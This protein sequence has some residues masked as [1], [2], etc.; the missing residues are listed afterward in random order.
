MKRSVFVMVLAL[1]TLSACMG[2]VSCPTCL[3][4]VGDD[5]VTTDD[6]LAADDDDAV[7]G[8]GFTF[9]PGPLQIEPGQCGA[10]V[11]TAVPSPGFVT[12][13]DGAAV[14]LAVPAAVTAFSD[15]ACTTVADS[16]AIA[17]GQ[18]TVYLRSV[19]S[20]SY[21][22]GA[23][24]AGG[25][26]QSTLALVIRESTPRR[27]VLA[28]PATA[29]RGECVRVNVALENDYGV[30]A[31]ADN[32]YALSF[33]TV[34]LV[35]GM[36]ASSTCATYLGGAAT[37]VTGAGSLDVF[38][39]ISAVGDFEISVEGSGL[40]GADVTVVVGQSQL[41]G[42]VDIADQPRFRTVTIAADGSLWAMMESGLTVRSADNGATWASRCH[43]AVARVGLTA[44]SPIVV[45]PTADDIGY[46][47]AQRSTNAEGAVCPSFGFAA[48]PVAAGP[49]VLA[50]GDL[51]AVG[52]SGA[53]RN[54]VVSVNQG[55]TWTV[56]KDLGLSTV[57]GI[58]VNPA[59]AQQILVS[60]TGG[61]Y[62]SVN[63][64]LDFVNVS[65]NQAQAVT[66]DPVHAGYVYGSGMIS[67]D[68]GA[69]W[70]TSAVYNGTMRWLLDASGAGYRFA[71]NASSTWVERAPDMRTPVWTALSAPAF[72]FPYSAVLARDMGLSVSADATKIAVVIGGELHLS[73]TSGVSYTRIDVPASERWKV[74]LAI[75]A[76][77]GT[78]L[79]GMTTD[80]LAVT[81]SAAGTWQRKAMAS[82]APSLLRLQYAG[83]DTFYATD[84]TP[85]QQA[86]LYVAG[87]ANG[88]DSVVGDQ[89]P[90][91]G[92]FVT[93]VSLAD[94]A[95]VV[96]ASRGVTTHNV[97]ISTNGAD[98]F[99]NSALIS[100]T[101]AQGMGAFGFVDPQDPD[102]VWFTGYATSFSDTRLWR[103]DVG[104]DV[105]TDMSA[106]TGIVPAALE[107]YPTT[108][109]GYTAVIASF[110]GELVFS[111]DGMATFSPPTPALD[112][113]CLLGTVASS[114]LD[115]DTIAVICQALLIVTRDAG[116]TW[117]AFWT[118]DCG[119]QQLAF[120]SD[121]LIV[122]CSQSEPVVIELP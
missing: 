35:G 102:V 95:R 106:A 57:T 76:P 5:D 19:L 22:M 111:T 49:E 24:V 56:R 98:D 81:R 20:G 2:G 29:Q 113:T 54:L 109:G 39:P 62:R 21:S 93:A 69:S 101:P 4:Q 66:Y 78:D 117:N 58:G 72:P 79:V 65:P 43:Y 13:A 33:A 6:E 108:G 14:A 3:D 51:Y 87:T 36:Y 28:A 83:A 86:G 40:T 115:R 7:P 96:V 99:T 120:T 74:G 104:T 82:R 71:G 112:A 90:F 37:L 68:G 46:F 118:P 121:Q 110:T 17:S 25:N 31:V 9:D 80:W 34:P 30:A 52:Y 70:T 122:S 97:A 75:S 11:M 15:A 42:D 45:G 12:P 50:N 73:T 63:G 67:D 44:D 88:F 59:D 84:A 114:P 107:M 89:T 91:A 23:S 10:V 60:G 92:Q 85:S 77:N 53:S 8:I 1:S 55:A 116:Q 100:L 105:L 27:V 119:S 41:E 94:P 64:G 26:R 47:Y 16:V 38:A 48:N 61:T 18:A 103:L 32:D